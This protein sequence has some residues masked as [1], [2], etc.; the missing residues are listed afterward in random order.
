[1]GGVREWVYG[2]VIFCLTDHVIAGY[3]TGGRQKS[4]V[5]SPAIERA[6]RFYHEEVTIQIGFSVL[7]S[8][9]PRE[10]RATHEICRLGVPSGLFGCLRP[11]FGVFP[12]SSSRIARYSF[13]SQQKIHS[14]IVS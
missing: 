8:K 14:K 9:L 13:V 10:P 11:I 4:A 6:A 2:R 5:Q 3:P 1:M 12:V 7:Q